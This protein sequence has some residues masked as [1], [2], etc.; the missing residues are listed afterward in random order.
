MSSGRGRSPCDTGPRKLQLDVICPR[1]VVAARDG[2]T[3]LTRAPTTTR[4][5]ATSH[6]PCRRRSGGDRG[7]QRTVTSG[8]GDRCQQSG[9]TAP[10]TP[11]CRRSAR[12]RA[13]RLECSGSAAAPHE[14]RNVLRPL[15]QSPFVGEEG[16]AE[17]VHPLARAVQSVGHSVLLPPH[18][19]SL[20][21]LPRSGV[22]RGSRRRRA[23][24]RAGRSRSRAL[25]PRPPWHS[26]AGCGRGAAPSRSPLGTLMASGRTSNWAHG[27]SMRT[28]T[29]PMTFPSSWMT[30][31]AAQSTGESAEG[32]NCARSIGRRTA[33]E[34]SPHRRYA[35][36]VS[37]SR[38]S[39]GQRVS[40]RVRT[41]HVRSDNARDTRT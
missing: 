11:G 12:P 3:V 34:R 7:A 13:P 25:L 21:Q 26:P 14:S 4:R 1:M 35:Q 22:A 31:M 16:V 36:I 40:R 29:L 8:P 18:A 23:E 32:W 30:S 33:T 10:G 19:D 27:S 2:T 38:S 39:A 17:A 15:A 6:P 24:V 28:S 20:H 5:R 41:G 37:S 9:A